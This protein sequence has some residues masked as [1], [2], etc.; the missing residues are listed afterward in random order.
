MSGLHIRLV[1]KHAL[2]IHVSV[3][4][5]VVFSLLAGAYQE[6]NAIG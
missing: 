5:S 2:R 1:F 4:M 3:L 6:D